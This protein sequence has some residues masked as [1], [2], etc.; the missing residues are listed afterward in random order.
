MQTPDNWV[1]LKINHT[2]KNVYKILAGWSGGYLDG[3]RWRISSDISKFEEKEHYYIF[4][5]YS[6][7]TYHCYKRSEAL[8]PNCAHILA[9]I[10]EPSPDTVDI[11]KYKD[12]INEFKPTV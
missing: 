9:Y 3:D 12:F 6:G 2:D 10:K 8:K 5:G 4:Y 11:I 7:S 1:I